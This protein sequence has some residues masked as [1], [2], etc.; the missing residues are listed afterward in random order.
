MKGW[1]IS[2]DGHEWSDDEATAGQACA[3]A[4]LIGDS[5][6]AVSPWSGP[7][8]LAAWIAVLHTSVSG[9]IGVSVTAVYGMPVAALGDCL[10]DRDPE[11]AADV[12]VVASPVFPPPVAA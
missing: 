1:T 11:P 3:V 8:S 5:W 9:D 7:K 12:A 10:S 6:D 2:F 4:E